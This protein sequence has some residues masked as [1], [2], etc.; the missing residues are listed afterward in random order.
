[1]ANITKGLKKLR[2][3]VKKLAAEVADLR[4]EQHSPPAAKAV[5]ETPANQQP[6]AAEASSTAS[7]RT[8]RSSPTTTNASS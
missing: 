4:S 5:V 3:R 8:P 1:M 2:K 6:A 7:P